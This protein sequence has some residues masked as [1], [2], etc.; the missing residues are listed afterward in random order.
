MVILVTGG[1]GFIGSQVTK[2]L[3]ERGDQVIIVDNFNNYYEPLLKEDRL[4]QLLAGF[5]PVVYRL[6]IADQVKLSEVFKNHKID[7]ICHLAAQ[8]GVR[9][10]LENPGV[11]IKSNIIGTHNLLELAR[12][13]K[14][15]DFVF[16]SS[17]SVYGDN[18]KIPFAETDVVDRPISLYAATKKANELEAYTYHKLFGLNVFGLRFFTVYGPWG[19]PDM[20]YFLFTKSILSSE[21]IKV[22]NQGKMKRDFTYIDDIVAGVV[23]ALDRVA[24][25][26][27]INLGNNQPITLEEFIGVIENELGKTAK[28]KYDDRQ[29]GDV[30]ETYA[31]ITK[32][33][34]VLDWQPSTSIKAGLKKFIG[35]YKS[36]YQV[37]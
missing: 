37:D 14:I 16:A 22:F 21:E 5:K 31:D 29:P 34:R 8:A 23:K 28:K 32:A 30:I 6:D 17:S 26:E 35:W 27:I 4:N 13:Y 12:E 20:A 24:G 33:K 7:K 1:A 2:S 25:Y 9:Y 18:E 11:Y 15:K 36:Y 19:R 10:S 3:L